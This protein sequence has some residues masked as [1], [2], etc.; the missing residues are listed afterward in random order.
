MTPQPDRDA[1]P[2]G[3]SRRALL[4][5]AG[6]GVAAASLG[7]IPGERI[8]AAKADRG[9]GLEARAS[10]MTVTRAPV[11]SAALRTVCSKYPRSTFP[12]QNRASR[13]CPFP[14]LSS[15]IRNGRGEEAVC[16]TRGGTC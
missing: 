5:G 16:S 3:I 15:A 9:S 6:L 10:P 7:W 2:V 1:K 11:A 14:C 13:A 12:E 4:A 8:P